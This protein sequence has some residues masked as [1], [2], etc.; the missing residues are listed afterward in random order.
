MWFY[1]L[2]NAVLESNLR[3]ANGNAV[4][5]EKISSAQ[6]EFINNLAL[7]KNLEFHFFLNLLAYKNGVYF[8]F[9][10]RYTLRAPI[11]RFFQETPKRSLLRLGTPQNGVL[12]TLIIATAPLNAIQ[13]FVEFVTSGP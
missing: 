2:D 4:C 6:R 8:P 7:L 9:S 5:S 13:T 1:T 10:A 12:I 11:L 3:S